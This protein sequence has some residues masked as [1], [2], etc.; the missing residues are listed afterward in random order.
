M[1]DQISILILISTL[2]LIGIIVLIVKSLASKPILFPKV[3]F[4]SKR[5]I[6][7]EWLIPIV[8]ISLGL[9]LNLAINW[10]LYEHQVSASQE[11]Q[12]KFDAI[13]STQKI[14]DDPLGIES[15]NTKAQ[16]KGYDV[17]EPEKAKAFPTWEETVSLDALP[18]H[19]PKPEFRPPEIQFIL[20]VMLV[21]YFI[22]SIA[23]A[24]TMLKIK[25]E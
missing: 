9:L 10:R 11:W 7:K 21:V 22:R 17:I 2:I 5:T 24:V 20:S 25:R 3:S 1:K 18:P 6:A 15:T 4:P 19:P 16:T 23:W 12:K 13:V 14:K 8:A